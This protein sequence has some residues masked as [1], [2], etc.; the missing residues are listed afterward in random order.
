MVTET[1]KLTLSPEGCD[2]AIRQLERYKKKIP[3]RNAAICENVAILAAVE[4]EKALKKWFRPDT[5]PY[6]TADPSDVK[7]SWTKPKAG[8]NASCSMTGSGED[9]LFIEF[10]AG[11]H[12][13]QN[14]HGSPHPKGV[15]L[16]Y[17][18]GDYSD[19]HHGLED[20][21]SWLD[22]S[23]EWHKSHGTSAVMPMAF[24]AVEVGANRDNLINACTLGWS[25]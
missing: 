14:P 12:F 7:F 15:E 23:G 13:N 11:V 25:T 24:A 8:V 5:P 17:T 10:G 9:L 4:A 22:P 20:E 1:I 21:W 19:L 16:G 2:K 18:I 6:E 3:K